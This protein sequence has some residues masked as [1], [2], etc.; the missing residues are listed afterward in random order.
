MNNYEADQVQF[1]LDRLEKVVGTLICWSQGNLL[2]PDEV[3]E[4]LEMLQAI[5]LVKRDGA[6]HRADAE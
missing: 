1:R 6:R 2:R 4:L 5:K 3:K